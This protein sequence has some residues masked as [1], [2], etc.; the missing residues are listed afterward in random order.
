MSLHPQD[1][2]VVPDNTA[3]VARAAFPKGNPYMTLRDE[4]G[5]IY[6]D[7]TFT[8]LFGSSR[9]R[10]A[11][12]PG[13]LALVT[14]LQFAENLTD[15]QAADAVR[16]R[17][18][19]KY[20]LGLELTDPGFD[21]TLLYEFRNRLLENEAEQKLLDEL[22]KLLQGRKL[23][24]SRGKQRTD[25][26][27]VLAAIRNLHRL[28]LV[29]ETMRHALNSLAVVVPDWLRA[30]VP[31]EWFDR[32]GPRFSDWRLPGSEVKR[33]A[34]A[35]TI[36]QDGFDLWEMIGQSPQAELL[37]R[38]P[39]V[40]T[41]RQVWLQQ[42]YGGEGKPR[43]RNP[44]SMP[45]SRKRI[46]SPYDTDA[47]FSVRRSIKWQGY[48][49]HVTETCDEDQP[50]LITNVETTTS[51]SLDL[52]WTD[53]IHHHL[54]EKD[55]LP[56]DHLVDAGYVDARALAEGRSIYGLDLIGPTK[57][58]PSRQARQ[59]K[60][61]S[62]ASFVIDWEK[63]QVTCP[64]GQVNVGWYPAQNPYGEPIVVAYWAKAVCRDCPT[65]RQ[66]IGSRGVPRVIKFLPKEPY[67]ALQQ[68]RQ[69]QT[70]DEF[71]KT[72]AQRAGVEGTISQGTQVCGLRRSRYRGMAK[73]R[74][75]HVFTAVAINLKRLAAWFEET[76]RAQTR[77]SRFA[78]LAAAA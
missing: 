75:Q 9:G 72:Y 56:T 6:E 27:Y 11:E 45:P 59:T 33:E 18:D 43:W 1:F 39:A 4:L 37:R 64:Q 2:S 12:S 62:L 61:Y 36:G 16:G 41:L 46:I 14:A 77:L 25:S 44:E 28:E 3:R 24:K 78:A 51:A 67:I 38:I 26:T 17:I 42:Y 71:K 74:L 52:E 15:R 47:R 13:C 48:R 69:R 22:L 34:L 70:T 19:W 29:G 57:P 35:E 54:Q 66:C 53:T 23:L 63:E 10:P 40:E 50:L 30:Q 49:V 76:P 60:L 21:Y 8:P 32:Y 20:L 55:L 68:A 7:H 58:N 73:T 31:A 5:V 65:R